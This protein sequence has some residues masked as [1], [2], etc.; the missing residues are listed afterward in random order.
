MEEGGGVSLV[1]RLE[2]G[3]SAREFG[4]IRSHKGVERRILSQFWNLD[5]GEAWVVEDPYDVAS[6]NVG[7][8]LDFT[9]SP[10]IING[11]VP[12]GRLP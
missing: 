3:R 8:L 10:K 12:D 5:Q 7:W 9:K 4:D 1:R 2:A 6:E 11:V